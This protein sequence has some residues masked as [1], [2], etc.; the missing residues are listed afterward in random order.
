M[1]EDA[2]HIRSFTSKLADDGKDIVM[3]MHSYGGICGT[4][5]AHGVVK[6]ERLQ[7][8]KKDGITGLLY[9]SSPIPRVGGSVATQMG[10]DMPG[11]FKVD[12]GKLDLASAFR[13]GRESYR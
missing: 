5:S 3:V 12:V 8:R 9:V 2:D 7:A 13:G 10:D 1:A 11:F 4:E 6:S